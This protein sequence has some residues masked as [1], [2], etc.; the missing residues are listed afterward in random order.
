MLKKFSHS[1]F[2]VLL[3][4]LL[5]QCKVSTPTASSDTKVVNLPD[6]TRLDTLEKI[7]TPLLITQNGDTLDSLFQE[8]DIAV[9][10]LLPDTVTFAAVG[11]IMMG[12]KFPNTSY[13]PKANGEYLWDDSR[14]LLRSADITFGNLE[15]TVL[16]GKGDQKNCSNPKACYLFKMPVRLTSNLVDAGFD[17]ISLANNHANDFG[18]PGRAS[19][20]RTLDSLGIAAAGSTERPYTI[21]KIG[22]LK[23]GLVAFAPNRGTLT[24]Y[25]EQRAKSIVNHLDSLTDIVVVSIHGGAEGSK[26]MHVTRETEYYYGENRGNIYAFSH[27]MIDAGADIIFGHGPH[28]VRGIEV[29]KNR[30]IAYSLGNFLT[31]GRFNLRGPNAEAPVLEVKTNA[32]GKFLSGQIHSFRQSYSYGPQKDAALRAMRSI[33][34]LTDEDFPENP[35]TVDDTGRIIYIQN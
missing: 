9:Y 29:Y 15:G 1:C 28:V 12:T 13:L 5:S 35:I 6:T 3:A 21:T 22:H 26:N 8:V 32:E 24:F 7:T 10:R 27:Q 4:L 18:A 17:L 19:T 33:R 31:Y 2:A 23:I 20:L 16:D 30:M 14:E 25:D 34:Q 11:D